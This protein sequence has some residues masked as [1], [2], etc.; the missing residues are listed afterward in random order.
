M[1]IAITGASGLIGSALV[2]FFSKSHRVTAID[3]QEDLA[4]QLEHKDIIIHLAG[5]N[6]AAHRWTSLQ[7]NKI[8][9]SRIEGTRKLCAAIGSLKERPKILFSASA[10]G[11]YGNRPQERLDEQSPVGGGF[12][13]KVVQDWEREAMRAK[14]Y[15]LRVVMMRFGVVLSGQGGMLARLTPLFRWGIG[16][17]MGS[18]TQMMSWIS[19]EEV[20]RIID[21]LLRYPSLEGPFNFVSPR[22]VSNIEF[23]KTL[24]RTLKKPLFLRT[25]AFLARLAM[26]EM[27]QEVIFSSAQV[28]PKRLQEAG[29]QFKHT[30]LYETLLHLLKGV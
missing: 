21:F 4:S 7:K 3:R 5:E 6:V 26:G 19:I 2:S 10:V 12:L 29:Y 27:A 23:S 30:D 8:R 22:S 14:E 15:G 28:L 11:Y 13:A 20:P 17:S 18:G 25:P 24:A 9:N 1:N 16:S